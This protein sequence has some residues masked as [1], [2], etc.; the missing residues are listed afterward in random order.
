VW[1]YIRPILMGLGAFWKEE[2]DHPDREVSLVVVLPNPSGAGAILSLIPQFLSIQF[3]NIFIYTPLTKERSSV[4]QAQ[5]PR[6]G[7]RLVAIP[8]R[9]IL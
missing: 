4:G 7:W 9:F 1:K 3:L 2:L 6:T 8:F 5:A